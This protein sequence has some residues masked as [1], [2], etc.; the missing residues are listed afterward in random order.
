MNT[1]IKYVIGII[2]LLIGGM[3]LFN[4]FVKD[5]Y[6]EPEIIDVEELAEPLVDTI[7]V[8]KQAVENEVYIEKAIFAKDGYIV[9]YREVAVEEVVEDFDGET[10]KDVEEDTDIVEVPEQKVSVEIIAVSKLFNEGEYANELVALQE[11]AEAVEGEELTAAIYIDN[12]DGVFNEVD[13]IMAEGGFASVM[14][15]VVSQGE[16]EDET[17]L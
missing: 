3:F 11:D 4:A 17:K 5:E 15:S 8:P 14:F 1:K 7:V 2:I 16:L 6:V 9:I 10:D 12:G 13:D